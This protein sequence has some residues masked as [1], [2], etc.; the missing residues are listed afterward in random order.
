VIGRNQQ[1]KLEDRT[2][3]PYTEAVIHE[4][5]RFGDIIPMSL[6]RRVTKDTKFQGFLLPKVLPCLAYGDLKHTHWDLSTLSPLQAFQPLSFFNQ[7]LSFPLRVSENLQIF[8]FR[9]MGTM[10][11]LNGHKMHFP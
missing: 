2:K 10:S 9:G 6:A 5:H 11:C 8:C 4:I 3:M 7:T 1:P